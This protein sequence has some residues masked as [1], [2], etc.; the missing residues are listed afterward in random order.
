VSEVSILIVDDDV[1]SQQALKGMLDSEGWRVRIVT[2][3]A[4]ALGELATGHWNLAIVNVAIAETRGP[5]FA[6]LRELSNADHQASPE[7]MQGERKHFRALFL[8]PAQLAKEAQPVL[9][10]CGLSYAL[11]PY[12]LHEFLEKVSELLVDSGAMGES[13][14]GI[15]GSIKRTD[16]RRAR[17]SGAP[18]RGAMFAAREAYQM[19]EEEINEYERQEDQERAIRAKKRKEHERLGS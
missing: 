14:R 11:K 15:G 9:E 8:V 6:I 2:T 19:T 16:P 1:A 5:L 7:A 4:D 18:E 10:R 3:A 17:S 12:H 13:L